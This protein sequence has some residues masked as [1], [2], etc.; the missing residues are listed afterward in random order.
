MKQKLSFFQK[1]TNFNQINKHQLR[2][3]FKTQAGK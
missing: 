3:F 2:L 1:V